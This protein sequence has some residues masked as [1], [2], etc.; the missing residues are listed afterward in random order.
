MSQTQS[1][2]TT[3]ARS[4]QQGCNRG[5]AGRRAGRHEGPR[6][7]RGLLREGLLNAEPSVSSPQRAACLAAQSPDTGAPCL[8]RILA[9]PLASVWVRASYLTP[10]C[11]GC[12]ICKMEIKVVRVK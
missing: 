9:R 3:H 5:A 6:R 11:L 10:L 7:E 12:L 4:G 8:A 2:L 1:W